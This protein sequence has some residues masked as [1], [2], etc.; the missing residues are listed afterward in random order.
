L[1]IVEKEKHIS[2]YQKKLIF[3]NKNSLIAFKLHYVNFSWQH[4]NNCYFERKPKSSVRAGKI[5]T[6]IIMKEISLDLM[7][8]TNG[9][10]KITASM[11]VCG[12]MGLAYS[13]I[14]VIG[15]AVG[16]G[17]ALTCA[18]TWDNLEPN[19]PVLFYW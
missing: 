6:I 13:F 10:G 17:V 14:P 11:L 19:D 3:C 7:A 4:C 16:F 18:A 1:N 15:W 5:L 8:K 12:G 2:V 9:G